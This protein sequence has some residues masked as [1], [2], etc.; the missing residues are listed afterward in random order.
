MANVKIPD[1]ASAVSVDDSDYFVL[2]TGVDTLK[3][4]GEQLRQ[5]MTGNLAALTTTAKG[6]AVAAINEV[7]AHADAA[8]AAAAKAE[9]LIITLSSV[10]ELP[11]TVNNAAI[12]SD[13]VCI[14]SEYSSSSAYVNASVTTSNGSLTVTG[15]ISGTTNITLYLMKSRTN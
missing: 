12:E 2:D 9:V 14:H 5:A 7:D 6:S 3:A 8:N 4:T 1:L 11:Q 13:M 15:S 10:T